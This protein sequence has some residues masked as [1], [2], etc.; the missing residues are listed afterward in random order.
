MLDNYINHL[1]NNYSNKLIHKFQKKQP[2]YDIVFEAGLFNGS[3]QMGFLK[4]IHQ[5]EKRNLIYIQRLSGSSVGSIVALCYFFKDN[6]SHHC[7]VLGNKLYT[8]MKKR[9][10]INIFNELGQYFKTFLP[11]DIIQQV[12]NKLYITYHNVQTG[13]QHVKYTYNNIDDL[14]ET[15]R[16]SCAIPF[17][18]DNSILYKNKYFDGLYPYMFKPKKN[19]RIINLNIV[20][21]EKITKMFSIRHE[22]TNT[23]RILEGIFDTHQFFTT[24]YS[25]NM[26]SFVDKWS[27]LE[28]VQ[29]FFFIKFLKI[30]MYIIHNMYLLNN[31]IKDSTNDNSNINILLKNA[32]TKLLEH[33]CF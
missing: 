2:K 9:K 26:C 7:E 19:I 13:K 31:L 3:Y 5:L 8:N 22:N 10:T 14:L 6:I 23:K 25:C 12:N 33:Y 11:P 15:I 18:I 24:Q 27:F 17:V 4:Y 1:I 20:N 30:I 32:C 29:Y 21:I 28:N 16:K